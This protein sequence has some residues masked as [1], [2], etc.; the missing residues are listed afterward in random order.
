MGVTADGASGASQLD[1]D[2]QREALGRILGLDGP[3]TED[4]IVAAV[5]HDSYAR[6]LL[7]ARREPELLA[8]LLQRPPRRPRKFGAG[9]LAARGSRALLRWAGTGFTTVDDDT[10]ARRLATCDVCPD[11]VRKEVGNPVCGRCG[12]RVR[13]KARLT[14]E[15]CPAPSPADPGL[16]RWGDPVPEAPQ[17]A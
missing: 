9:E 14:S 8:D 5:E 17:V 10:Y 2:D 16:T 3:V 7:L 12:C 15:S 6:N 4:V 1:L 13:W 11:L